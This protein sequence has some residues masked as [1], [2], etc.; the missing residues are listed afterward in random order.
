MEIRNRNPLFQTVFP[1]ESGQGA[2]GGKGLYA[3]VLAFDLDAV[4]LLQH[5]DQFQNVD[6]ID[7]QIPPDE[8]V[9]VADILRGDIQEGQC[10]NDLDLQFRDKRFHFLP[11]PNDNVSGRLTGPDAGQ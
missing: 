1:D 11:L 6:G 7:P 3:H 2:D 10:I 9:I 4:I 5:E 8:Q